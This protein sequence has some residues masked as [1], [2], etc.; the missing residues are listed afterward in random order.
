MKI[1]INLL[2]YSFGKHG[3]AEVYIRNLIRALSELDDN[4]HQFVLFVTP[5]GKGQ[6]L[7]VNPNHFEEIVLPEWSAINRVFRI[8]AE[9]F[10]LPGLLNRTSIDCLFSNYAVPIF[11]TI[12]QIVNVHDMIYKRMPKTMEKSKRI[13]WQLMI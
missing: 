4:N 9:Q 13:Y 2:P 5:R 7:P 1:G 6:Y 10:V 12:P 3:G 8:T 11:S